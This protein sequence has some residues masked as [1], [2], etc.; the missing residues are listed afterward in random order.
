MPPARELDPSSSPLAFFG[1]ELREHRLRAG[2]S[3]EQLADR[4]SYS[5]SLVCAV[6]LARRTP[7]RDFAERADQV[8]ETGGELSRLW[9]LVRQAVYPAWFRPWLEIEQT[10]RTLQTWQPLLIPGLLQT[11]D[12]AREVLQREPG[13]TAEQAE[14]AVAAR[15]TRQSVL[16]KPDPPMFWAVLDEWMLYRPVGSAETMRGQMRALRDSAQLPNVT[17]Q[18]VPRDSPAVPGLTGAFVIAK[19]PAESDL[20][21]LESAGEGYVTDRPA[22]VESIV[23]RYDVIRSLALP[24]H[25]SLHLLAKAEESI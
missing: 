5:L 18:V 9:P 12:Y 8:L 21:Y 6:E 15:M 3:Q 11:E 10:A 22:D 14:E 2:L 13:A 7:S 25:A 17:I 19:V 24:V 4:L 23:R 1:A 16:H 20:V